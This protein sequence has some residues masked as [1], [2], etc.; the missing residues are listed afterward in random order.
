MEGEGELYE[1]MVAA[2][3]EYL[4]PGRAGGAAKETSDRP[5]PPRNLAYVVPHP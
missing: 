5:G 1:D 4:Y 3:V 2:L